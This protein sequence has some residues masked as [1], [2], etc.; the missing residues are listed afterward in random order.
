MRLEIPRIRQEMGGKY[1][2]ARYAE[3]FATLNVAAQI[4][5]T[6]LQDRRFIVNSEGLELSQKIHEILDGI[7]RKNSDILNEQSDEYVIC[8]AL[9]NFYYEAKERVGSQ[10][11]IEDEKFIYL[12]AEMAHKI[13]AEWKKE[14]GI[15][16]C[17]QSRREFLK[18]CKACGLIYIAT[19]GNRKRLTHK[20]PRRGNDDKRYAKFL[21]DKILSEDEM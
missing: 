7:M 19:E 15:H 17:F 6:Y 12:Q 20:L 4:L 13:V 1:A 2:A 18:V 16:T 21:K 10:S 3:N 14:Q 11:I 5:I 8:H 9:A